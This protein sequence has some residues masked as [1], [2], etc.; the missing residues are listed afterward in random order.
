MAGTVTRKRGRAV[1]QARQDSRASRNER[2]L[3]DAQG[4]RI[5][6]VLDLDEYRRLVAGTQSSPSASTSAVQRAK[7]VALARQAKGSWK[8]NEGSGTAVEI[9][10]RLRDEWKR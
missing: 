4:K 9:V 6:V 8:E 5:A 10:R 2:Y 1:S 7:F 3:V